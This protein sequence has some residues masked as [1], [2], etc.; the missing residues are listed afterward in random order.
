[1]PQ[2]R[3]VSI[4]G[5]GLI[6]GSI[7]LALR[8]GKIAGKVIGF[9]KHDQTVRRAISRKAVNDGDTELCPEWLSQSDL[10]VLAVPPEQV[11]PMARKVADLTKHSF[12]MTDA[13]SV[14]EPV[15]SALESW[16]PPRIKFVGS[17]PMAG[18]E[19][20]GIEA[21]TPELFKG[22][23]CVVTRTQKTDVAAEKQVSAF[24]KKLGGKVVTLDP[25][26]HDTLVAQISHVP[27]LAAASLAL[28]PDEAALPL[29]GGGFS[30][31]TRIALSDPAMWEQICRM[32][33]R[34]ILAGLDRLIA[35]LLSLKG[36]V[37][38]AAP[39]AL[40]ATLK[41]AQVRRARV[42]R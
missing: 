34:E 20:S 23:A 19:R 10:V 13:A 7:G 26:R 33:R 32:N 5:L 22:A 27:H 35:G 1:M 38:S 40:K 17:H 39:G 16:L 18:S 31:T 9:A 42:Q 21:A 11:V 4:I 6:G 28:L 25:K 41:G 8:K 37:A 36:A 2:F 24:W 3:Q 12:I 30:D 29:A 14:K 15:V